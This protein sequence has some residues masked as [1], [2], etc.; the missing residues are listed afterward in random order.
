MH[1]EGAYLCSSGHCCCFKAALLARFALF[2]HTGIENV[3]VPSI[4]ARRDGLTAPVLNTGHPMVRRMVLSCLRHWAG[5]YCCDGFVFANAENL[6]QVR[7]CLPVAMMANHSCVGPGHA[8]IRG[9]GNRGCSMQPRVQHATE[10]AACNQW[11]SNHP[12][13]GPGSALWATA[14][15]VA[16]L[17]YPL[18]SY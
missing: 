5:E 12:V 4:P 7:E 9:V 6:C 11:G 13:H 8:G 10:G 16:G 15:C 14:V 1:G 18:R 3:A 17:V 2:L